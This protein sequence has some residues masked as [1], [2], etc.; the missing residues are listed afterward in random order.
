MFGGCI[1]DFSQNQ[2]K[3]G[4]KTCPIKIMLEMDFRATMAVSLVLPTSS[5]EINHVLMKYKDVFSLKTTPVNASRSLLPAVIDTG[6]SDPIRQNP[7]RMPLT[8][9]EKLKSVYRKC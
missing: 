2:M 7:Y 1:L 5:T 9:R 8:K 6:D 3:L 4:E